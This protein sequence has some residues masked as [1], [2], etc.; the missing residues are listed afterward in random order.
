MKCKQASRSVRPRGH[1]T[2]GFTLIELMIVVTIIAI[3]A[4]IAY[5]SY[6]QY[7]KRANRSAA[8]QL[9]LTIQNREEQYILDARAYTNVLGTSGLNVAHEGYTCTPATTATTCTN[10]FYTVSV[11]VTGGTP[12][13]YS[14]TA[15]PKAG[16]YQDGGSTPANTD[17]TL[18][19]TSAG[20]RSRT[21]LGTPVGDGKW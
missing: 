13:S 1:S 12:P 19:L 6:Q 5:P 16:S 3:L 2:G 11:T 17:G 21:Y 14:I 9:M 4:A 7:N 18:T 10:N 8:A 20:N 15:V